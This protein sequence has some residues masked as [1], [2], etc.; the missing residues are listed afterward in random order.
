MGMASIEVISTSA[1][2][3][4]KY[5]YLPLAAAPTITLA[6]T[7]VALLIG[8]ILLKGVLY[9]WCLRVLKRHPNNESVKAISQDNQNDVLSNF[10]ALIAAAATKLG[11][12]WWI[13]DP[14]AGIVISLYIIYTWLR[15]GY[16]QVEM[17]VGKRADAEF[18]RTIQEL[19]ET[20]NSKMVLDHLCAYHF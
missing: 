7:T 12:E 3:L 13:M 9:V 5:W 17:I 4:V 19:A 1:R 20:H 14:G 16:E 15:T 8:V 6:P 2:Q 11:P 10:S 18:L